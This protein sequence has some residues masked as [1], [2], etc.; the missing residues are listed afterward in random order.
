MVIRKSTINDE[1][2][3]RAR[4]FIESLPEYPPG[5][6]RVTVRDEKLGNLWEGAL[7]HKP[8]VG[9]SWLRGEDDF[10]FEI[11]DI[12]WMVD[13]IVCLFITVSKKE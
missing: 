1:N 4:R 8:N 13:P 11:I 2:A 12:T 5:W 10:Y 7:S 6:I 3:D 9:E